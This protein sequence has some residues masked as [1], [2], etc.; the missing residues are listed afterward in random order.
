MVTVVSFIGESKVAAAATGSA[1]FKTFDEGRGVAG[2][3]SAG[4][5][6]LT[7]GRRV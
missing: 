2:P 6:R 7:P 1:S 5:L 3:A 4:R